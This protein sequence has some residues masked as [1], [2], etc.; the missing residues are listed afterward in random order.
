[1]QNPQVRAVDNMKAELRIG[2]RY[3]YATGSFQPG[4]G[5]VG[6]S[7]LVSTQFQFADVGVN[8]VITPKVHSATE[9]SLH[10]ELDIS[11]VKDTINVGGLSQ[12]VIGQRKVTHDI[13]IR[14]GEITLLGG[15]MQTQDTKS[16]AGTPGI[17]NIP[18]IRNIFGTNS[19]EKDNSEL[20]IALV[21]H[22]VRSPD[23]SENNLR[24]VATGNDQ[25]VKL[26]YNRVGAAVGQPA[27]P[28]PTGQPT[29]PAVEAPAP[30][31]EAP[32]PAPSAPA[33]AAGPARLGL[34]TTTPEAKPGQIVT[35]NLVV[36]NV[37]DLYGAPLH[38]K[39]DQKLLRL[40]EVTRGTFLAGDGQNIIFTRNIQND[41]G[42]ATIN[43]NRLPGAGGVSGSGTL[44]SFVFQALAPG[45]ATVAV[46]E[47]PLR[48]S[49]LQ[50]ITLQPPLI[51]IT[52]KP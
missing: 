42:E 40:N 11:Q 33:P 9:V 29:P 35:V 17:M 13:R 18:G 31:A 4:V 8:V 28:A 34:S 47:A 41:A 22:I 49:Q 52:I 12:P 38:L 16:R 15:L 14:E 43:L 50:P 30:P 23:Y 39:F 5:T 3:P 26:N 44:L 25:T 10:V 51:P 19:S 46:T 48:N 20:M 45:T 2:D 24:A 37:T 36:E 1:M 6:V 27:A 7:P 32:K 21:P